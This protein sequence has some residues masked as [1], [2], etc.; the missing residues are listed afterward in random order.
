MLLV[1]DADGAHTGGAGAT[2]VLD[3]NLGTG[4]DTYPAARCLL[5]GPRYALLREEVLPAPSRHDRAPSRLLLMFGGAP[6]AE[7]QQL[8]TVVARHPLLRDLEI[9]LLDGASDAP[10]AMRWADLAVA[11]AGTSSWELCCAGVPAVLV[12]VA[13]NQ[14]PVASAL[15]A[16]G[17]AVRASPDPDAIA[18]AVNAL[19][20][21]DDR[22]RALRERGQALV[23]GLGA[24][25]AACV[26]RSHLLDLR[27]VTMED[28]G[29]LLEWANDPMTRA[30][31]FS[32]TPIE[33]D[34]HL[35]W[36]RQ[37]TASGEPTYIASDGRGD[38]GVVRFDGIGGQLE[39]GLTVAPRRRGEGWAGSLVYAGCAR[40][41]VDHGTSGVVARVKPSNTASSRAFEDADFDAVTSE[42][43]TVLRYARRLDG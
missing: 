2:I 39:V 9:R 40:V 26:L 32:P 15:A 35:R 1:D 24:R 7:V 28:A 8:A 41:R 42:D 36:L 11:A 20:R 16:A 6:T 29:T 10:A 19:R 18:D 37:R 25:R 31:S 13:G 27:P 38:L 17:A 34:D 23:D 5:L 4:P 22:R 43:P 30:A 12:P 21:D 3:Q 14:E 33:L